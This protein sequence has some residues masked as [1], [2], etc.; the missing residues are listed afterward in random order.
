MK[1]VFSAHAQTKYWTLLVSVKVASKII[2]YS[3]FGVEYDFIVCC[4]I[5]LF[6]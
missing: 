2:Y 6:V 5:F 3:F 4:L 1:N